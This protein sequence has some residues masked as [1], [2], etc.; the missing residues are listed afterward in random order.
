MT[1]VPQSPNTAA[2]ARYA[3]SFTSDIFKPLAPAQAPAFLPAGKRR[4]QTTSEMFGN[5]NDKELRAM[6]KTFVPK[7]DYTSSRQKRQNFLSS[8]V[9]PRTMYGGYPTATAPS[10]ASP[11][12]KLDESIIEGEDEF[13]KGINPHVRR[14]LELSSEL[15]GRETPHQ[16][17]EEVQD[18]RKR[19]TPTDYKWFNVPEP[20]QSATGGKEVTYQDRS[21]FE[22]CSRV[23]DHNSPQVQPQTQEQKQEEAEE[24]IGDMKRRANVYYSDL[25]GRPTPMAEPDQVEHRHP[26]HQGPLEEQIVVHQDWTDS[27]T[28]LM[29]GAR[30]FKTEA[31]NLRKSDE[32]YQTRFLNAKGHYT[33]PDHLAPVTTDNSGKVKEAFGLPPQEIHQ[34]HLRSSATPKEFYEE[35]ANTRHWEVIELHISGLREDAD[36]DM[37]KD[38]CRNFDL[39]IVKVNVEVDPVRNLCKGRAKIMV[40]YNP[41]RDSISGLV[42]KLQET[43]LRVEV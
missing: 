37:V 40:R 33:P 43:K 21:Y 14:Q 24:A 42:Q 20:V 41:M 8:D 34:A 6:P 2:R 18:P 9:L 13:D 35:A 10:N 22:K 5:Y 16:T 23:F 4:D 11:R 31:P 29:C 32:Y 30:A 15:F 3:Q 38:I 27:R 39:Q 17:A 36:E 25:F 26:K 28:E 1:A 7:S 12:S 19:L